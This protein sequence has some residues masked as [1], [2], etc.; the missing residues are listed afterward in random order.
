[1]PVP[2]LRTCGGLLE[3]Q[4]PQGWEEKQD[5]PILETKPLALVA[6][7]H[8]VLG[9]RFHHCGTSTGTGVRCS[10]RPWAGRGAPRR[11]PVS[12]AEGKN[13]GPD[14]DMVSVSGARCGTFWLSRALRCFTTTELGSYV[15][16]VCNRQA[17]ISAPLGQLMLIHARLSVWYKN[18][19]Q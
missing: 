3:R 17:A 4:R 7:S 15:N 13:K 9:W 1:M 19:W 8:G 11:T 5:T 14:I 18:K 6:C 10:V 16:A 2:Y 12:P